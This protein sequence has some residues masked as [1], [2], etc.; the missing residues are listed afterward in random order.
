M[1]TNFSANFIDGKW[2]EPFGGDTIPVY[3]PATGEIMGTIAASSDA[4]VDN[5]VQAARRPLTGI[6][7][8]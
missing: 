2:V 4:D 8:A 1:K 7:A 6:G 5:A 3:E